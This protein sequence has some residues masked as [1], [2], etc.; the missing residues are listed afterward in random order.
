MK[1]I[2]KP[3]PFASNQPF[4]LADDSDKVVAGLRSAL[5]DTTAVVIARQDPG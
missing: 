4:P 2:I 3:Y 5:A 1:S